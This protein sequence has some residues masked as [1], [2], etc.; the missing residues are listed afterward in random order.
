MNTFKTRIN[1]LRIDFVKAIA[2]TDFG[3]IRAVLAIAPKSVGAIRADLAIAPKCR[4]ALRRALMFADSLGACHNETV[5]SKIH[6][7]IYLSKALKFSKK[8]GI[9]TTHHIIR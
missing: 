8:Q 1:I 5:V 2:P 9:F 6:S 3:A 4:G 7:R